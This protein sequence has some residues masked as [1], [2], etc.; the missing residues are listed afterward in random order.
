MCWKHWS[1]YTGEYTEWEKIRGKDT[2]THICSTDKA[3]WL[4]GKSVVQ[5]E[6]LVGA[7]VWF[8]GAKA[9]EGSPVVVSIAMKEVRIAL[10]L[11]FRLLLE[12]LYMAWQCSL[13]HVFRS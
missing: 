5:E 13:K 11:C 1:W 10:E 4:P 6:V 12:K 8:T 9:T 3:F 2:A 7:F